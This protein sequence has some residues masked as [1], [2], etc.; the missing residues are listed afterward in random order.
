MPFGVRFDEGPSADGGLR[1]KE[2]TK[3]KTI[4]RKGKTEGRRTIA[5]L[6]RWTRRRA[7]GQR[8]E[9]RCRR[10]EIRKRSRSDGR[11]LRSGEG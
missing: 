1:L 2:R 11:P 8:S 4:S 3:E 5:A 6:G 7:R 9:V 10:T